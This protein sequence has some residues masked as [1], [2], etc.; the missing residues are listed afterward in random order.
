M[1]D[2][3]K[4]IIGI[5]LIIIIINMISPVPTKHAIRVD[6]ETLLASLTSIEGEGE[7]WAL[8]ENVSRSPIS[9]ELELTGIS[10]CIAGT[11]V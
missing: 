4:S 1:L 2:V 10:S 9:L 11:D 5:I 8:V 6:T 7:K 3:L